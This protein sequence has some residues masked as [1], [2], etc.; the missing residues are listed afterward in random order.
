MGLDQIIR[1]DQVRPT[2]S[3]NE[4]QKEEIEQSIS[5]R[6][7]KIVR[8]NPNRLA[9]KTRN[10]TLSYLE[11]NQIA[12]RVARTILSLRG[13]GQEPVALLLDHDAPII[14]AILGTL[15]AGKICVPLDPSF[16]RDRLVYILENCQAHLV[17]TD[18]K[19]VTTA[20]NLP[21]HVDHLIN[22]DDIDGNA[23]GENLG[24]SISP[25]TLAYILYTSGST[26][27]PKGVIHNHRNVIHNAMRYGNGCNIHEEDRVTLLASL[28]TGQ[29]TPTAFSA[30]LNGATLY[31][32]N[33]REEGIAGLAEWLM[34]EEITVYISAPTVFRHFVATLTGEERFPKLR[35]IR[36]GAEQIRISDVD[37]YKRHFAPHC[38]FGVFL[39]ATETGNFSQYFIHKDTEITGK[40]VPVGYAVQDMEILL[41]DETGQEVSK[42]QPGEIAVRSRYLSP[43]YWR[44][45]DLTR[46]VFI[47]DPAGGD[48]KT[49]RTG[50]LG[51]MRPDGCLEHLGRKDF[52]VKIRGFS[53]ELEEI[54]AA[55][56]TSPVVQET[57]VDVRKNESQDDRLIAYI[58]PTRGQTP[59]VSEIRNYLKEK[60]PDYMMPSAF[61]FL[62]ALPLTPTGKVDR[63]AL[64]KPDESRPWLDKAFVAPQDPME[65]HLTKIW[66]KILGIQPIGVKDNFFDLGGD[67]LRAVQLITQIERVFGKPIPLPVL[68]YLPTIAQLASILREEKWLASGSSLVPVQTGGSKL[69]FFWI[70][71][72]KSTALLPHYLGPDQPLY[73]LEHQSRDGKPARYK[74]VK[75]I[76]AHY[77]EEI[78]VVQPQGPYFLGGYSLGGI[79]AFEAA[80]QLTKQGEEV[81]FLFLLD[82][83][84]PWSDIPSSRNVSFRDE[85]HRHFRNIA[86]LRYEEKLTYVLMR[87]KWRINNA[88][89]NGKTG[90][91]EFLKKAVCKV[92]FA[93]GH[94][95][96]PY[97]REFYIFHVIYY[98]ALRNYT[99][100]LYPGRAIYIKAENR[101]SDFR[102]H[103]GRLMAG[104]L[105]VHEVPG[106]HLDLRVEP[107]LHFWAKKL[108]TCLSHAQTKK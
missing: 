28:G 37:L 80:Q 43:G 102:F 94:P 66:E 104:G 6:Y 46:A 63:R 51:R 54:E 105:E 65:L 22:L 34:M 44:N 3:L 64:P 55:L 8:L 68:F 93:M 38:I 4:F 40:I 29:G 9:V 56:R 12:N 70:H 1:G 84:F 17:V 57:I 39:S 5:D 97:L 23:S 60:L 107:N 72:D 78:R 98:Q 74:Q 58:V 90:I 77:L 103:W 108:K 48:K 95:L 88:L 61:V 92:Y 13:E 7:E 106:N 62:E 30:L 18:N 71:G 47:L 45:S 10:I 100:K 27:Q 75:T 96:P 50:D 14:A 89:N 20:Y 36:L 91:R 32:F 25:D 2:N 101:R 15:K 41:L 79:V 83:H 73:G 82:S 21:Q 16:P 59:T 33:I 69:P 19:S 99:P 76:A 81:A 11:L 52:R 86:L 26:G 87:V 24:L 67:S 85:V 31:P 49:Y 35:M 42:N 53:I